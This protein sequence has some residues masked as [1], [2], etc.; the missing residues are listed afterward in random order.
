MA[1]SEMN[2]SAG[3]G[4]SN[5][6]LAANLLEC[7]VLVKQGQKGPLLRQTIHDLTYYLTGKTVRE[8]PPSAAPTRAASPKAVPRPKSP[9]RQKEPE[10]VS[11]HQHK[12]F[13]GL[14]KMVGLDAPARSEVSKQATSQ[15]NASRAKADLA[16]LKQ[17]QHHGHSSGGGSWFGP[18]HHEQQEWCDVHFTMGC[19]C[20]T[21]G[22]GPA[23]EQT[24]QH[25]KGP[26]TVAAPAASAKSHAK[27]AFQRPT[28]PKSALIANGWI[29]QQRRSKM[30]TVWKEVLASV[31]EGR[32]AGEETTLWIQR[33]IQ[34]AITGKT[35]LEVLHQIPVKW[36]QEIIY[37]DFSTDNRFVLKVYNLTEEFVF[38]C[39]S[40]QDAAQNWVLTLRSTQEIAQRN[41]K[42]SK[43]VTGVD[44]WDAP[45]RS[46]E[47]EKKAETPVPPEPRPRTTSA[48]PAIAPCPT[49][50][51]S[52]GHHK[53][54]IK[55]L[56]AIAH[57]AGV[58]TVGM[59]RGELERVVQQIA[60][61]SM[62][63]PVP[64]PQ[65]T[66]QQRPASPPAG[67]RSPPRTRVPTDD[68]RR[69]QMEAARRQQEEKVRKE[70]EM[71]RRQQIEEETRRKEKERLLQEEALRRQAEEAARRKAAEEAE[72][73]KRKE[74]EEE[75]RRLIAERIRQQ[76]IAEQR[77]KEEEERRRLE[78]ER[79]RREEEEH[80]RRV[81][82]MQAAEQ[83]RRQEEQQRQ[84]QQQWTQQQQAWQK[85]QAE[86]EQRRRMAEQRAAEE[87]RRQ[88]EA[89]RRQQQQ[90]WQQQTPP[91]P[92]QQ[93]QQ[94]PRPQQTPHTAPPFHGPP[95]PQQHFPQGHPPPGSSPVNM[96]YARMAHQS[97]DDSQMTL[98][99]IKHGVLVHWALQPPTLQMLRPIEML[100]TS[101]HTVFPPKFG[102][103]GHE[104]FT[105]WSAVTIEEV[106]QGPGRPDDEKLKKV[107]R[108]LRFFLHPDKLPRDFSKEQEYMC[109]M[110]WDITSDAWEEHK[111]K[112]EE[113]GWIRG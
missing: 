29:E 41:R 42:G 99:A 59:E 94:Q 22:S 102:V 97:D 92:Q 47:E 62:T 20:K 85:Q 98:H 37:Q 82:E 90:Q 79:V 40:D 65:Q 1:A 69:E 33:E 28:N 26:P 91:P 77:K 71:A 19:A 25:P 38:R 58:T 101:I 12:P 51:E 4:I 15:K 112:E 39:A 84:Q 44:E 67:Q 110:L 107:V 104:H 23:T 27:P 5:E 76:Q 93:W 45:R 88:E 96:K 75:H 7:A 103:P 60:A 81:A 57:G 43:V 49:P 80:R 34:H 68:A 70:E 106:C 17:Q 73:R 2:G 36:L 66:P 24:P 6:R 10:A 111:R 56:R 55:E 53:M 54:S 3:E 109:K 72:E 30:R 64:Q 86:E 52:S 61:A 8:D 63:G 46:I 31:V 48:P 74:E 83:R 14:A 50:A 9:P 35:E 89:F 78:E 13:A 108:K 32:K 95:P 11:K 16:E 113:L 87:R 105:K 21:R 18:G 100:I